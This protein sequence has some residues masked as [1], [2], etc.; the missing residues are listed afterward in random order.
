MNFDRIAWCYD[1]LKRLVFGQKLDQAA[2]FHLSEIKP[3]SSVLVIGGGT[4]EILEALP[5]ETEV[6]YVEESAKMIAKARRHRQSN[7]LWVNKNF[8]NYHLP[9]PVDHVVCPFILDLFDDDTLQGMIVGIKEALSEHGDLIVTD[10]NQKNK[11][12]LASMLLFFR[13]T[14][15]VPAMKL[16]SIHEKLLEAKFNPIKSASFMGDFVFSTVYTIHK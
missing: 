13:I 4:G 7:I 16:P 8:L 5:K 14:S 10:F 9:R 12:L 15:N 1:P 11:F 2:K 6:I 3:N